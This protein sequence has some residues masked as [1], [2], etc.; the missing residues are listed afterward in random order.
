[1]SFTTDWFSKNV[2]IWQKTLL[3][4]RDRE[5]HALEIGCFEGRASV[6]MCE[7]L[8]THPNSTLTVVDTFRGSTE[9]FPARAVGLEDRFDENTRAH[10]AKLT[11]I[12]S[13]SSEALRKMPQERQFDVI[14]IDGSHAAI[15]VLSD[16]VLAFPLLAKGGYLIFDDYEWR[17]RSSIYA[18]PKIAVDAFLTVYAEEVN[19]LHRAY[20]VIVSRKR[21]E[22]RVVTAPP[23]WRRR[24][25]RATAGT[26]S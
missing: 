25:R 9:H 5:A 24:R 16:A 17:V 20:Q 23:G 6:W 12:R 14:Y 10:A 18:R 22:E 4:V 15:D 19:L 2:P 3:G 13:F 21:D 11:K 1:M 7:N 26:A 8:L